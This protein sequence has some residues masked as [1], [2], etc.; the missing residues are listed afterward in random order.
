MH[1]ELE[2]RDIAVRGGATG[3]TVILFKGEKLII[4]SAHPDFFSE[5]PIIAEKIHETFNLKDNDV[6]AVISTSAH[7]C[8]IISLQRILCFWLYFVYRWRR[9][10]AYAK[11]RSEEAI[12]SYYT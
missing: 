4:P 12:L 5:H 6:V 7:A 2:L 3:A 8:S 11:H 10:L 9:A 1:S